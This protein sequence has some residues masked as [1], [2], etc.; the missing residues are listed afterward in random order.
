MHQKIDRAE[1]TTAEETPDALRCSVC[2]HLSRRTR[3]GAAQAARRRTGKRGEKT[4]T[5]PQFQRAE[6][7][8]ARSSSQRASSHYPSLCRRKVSGTKCFRLCL[9]RSYYGAL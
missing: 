9:Q 4:R 2:L 1:F 7:L 3:E 8:G 6:M 5:F